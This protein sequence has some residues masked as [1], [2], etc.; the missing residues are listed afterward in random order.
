MKGA[1][2]ALSFG[3]HP[4]D[5]E[6]GCGGTE[7]L[8]RGQGCEITHAIATS[9]EAGHGS[10]N[11]A[12]LAR[13]RESEATEAAR[14]IGA[15]SVEFLRLQDGLTHFTREQKIRVIALIRRVRPDVVFVHSSRDR[16]PDHRVVHE[17][18]MTAIAGAAGPW[19]A[20]AG[21]SPHSPR[22]VYGYEVWHPLEAPTTF[23]D[24]SSV[25]E[26]KIEAIRCHRSQMQPI[27]Y[28]DAFLGLARYRGALSG[29]GRYAEAFEVV[30]TETNFSFSSICGQ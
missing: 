28:D 14:R 8:L 19:Y 30:R 20:E 5:I 9:G 21:G 1:R 11:P 2:S 16:F 26:R 13:T 24:I 4:D 17:L 22:S 25:I 10:A 23:V 29:E 27:A 18:V 15:T 7:L 12:E 6:I 3:A